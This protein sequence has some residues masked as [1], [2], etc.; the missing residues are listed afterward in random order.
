MEQDGGIHLPLSRM[1]A[2]RQKEAFALEFLKLRNAEKA[3]LSVGFDKV[4]AKAVGKELERDPFVQR[5]LKAYSSAIEQRLQIE[6]EQVISDLIAIKNDAMKQIP[7]TT[8][9]PVTGVS[10]VLKDDDGNAITVMSDRKAAIMALTK[11]GENLGMWKGSG[12]KRPLQAGETDAAGNKIEES[13]EQR[14]MRYLTGK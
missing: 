12:A 4:S 13:A 9:N 3:A 1:N 11:I 7:I 10:E 14:A 2:E 5:I 6:T 8:V